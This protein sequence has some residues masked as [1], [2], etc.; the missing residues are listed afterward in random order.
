MSYHEKFWR[1]DDDDNKRKKQTRPPAR[2]YNEPGPMHPVSHA[3]GVNVSPE[4]QY[5]IHVYLIFHQ[6][7]NMAPGNFI[8]TMSFR[9]MFNDFQGMKTMDFS[10]ATEYAD[11]LFDVNGGDLRG[12]MVVQ[13][14][15]MCKIGWVKRDKGKEKVYSRIKNCLPYAVRPEKMTDKEWEERRVKGPESRTEWVLKA[16]RMLKGERHWE[17][18]PEEQFKT[19]HKEVRTVARMNGG[20]IGSRRTPFDMEPA[21]CLD[22]IMTDVRV[23][24]Y[25]E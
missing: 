18:L 24:L 14:T 22:K 25:S 15:F 7:D 23:A 16:I 5:S 1:G 2:Q 6:F 3:P 11:P 20:A 13:R 4:H 9:T 8:A 10:P 17:K 12:V 21:N 19:R